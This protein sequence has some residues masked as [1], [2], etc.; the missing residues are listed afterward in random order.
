M[1]AQFPL[2]DSGSDDFAVEPP[3]LCRAGRDVTCWR[4]SSGDWTVIE[5]VG[6]I[7]VAVTPI[8][9]EVF[10]GATSLKVIFDLSR[11]T[12]MDASGLTVLADAWRGGLATGGSVRLVGPDHRIRRLL[13]ITQFD[14][15]L[16]IFDC[17]KEATL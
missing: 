2:L 7:D 9:Q 5:V 1:A 6:E 12:F 15:V 11:V 8:L 16:P 13:E 17:L 4:Y 14:K 3:L 10:E